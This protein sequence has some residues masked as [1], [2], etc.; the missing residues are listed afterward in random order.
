MKVKDQLSGLR[1]LTEGELSDK[2]INSQK[3]LV[4]KHQEKL[5]GKLKNTAE[6]NYLKKEIARMKT[7][8]DEK[9]AA[10][11]EDNIDG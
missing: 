6:L 7:I 11:L 10:R 1:R 3:N 2:I 5:L 4:V 8:L 9:V